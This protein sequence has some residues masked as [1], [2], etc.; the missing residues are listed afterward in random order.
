M[1]S[2][3]V[4]DCRASGA[5]RNE[6][7]PDSSPVKRN[8]GMGDI[9]MAMKKRYRSCLLLYVFAMVSVCLTLNADIATR[10][11][12]QD[13]SIKVGETKSRNLHV[14]EPSPYVETSPIAISF[15]PKFEVPLETWDVIM[16][17]LNILA[18]RH[19]AVYAL[20]VGALGNMTDYKMDGIGIAG[21]FNSVGE[22]DGAFLVAGLVNFAAFDF[23]G[24]Q[25]SGL[26]SCSEGTHCGLQVGIVNYVGKLVGAQIGLVNMTERLEG[27]QLGFMNFNKGPGISFLPIVNLAF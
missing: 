18:G 23:S 17:R 26:Y 16:F 24:C 13:D 25:I 22:S 1:L 3:R 7:K 27:V 11:Y 5:T 4:N 21:L 2:I 8:K 10:T 19:R 9:S 20:D 15:A 6:N 12:T 14:C